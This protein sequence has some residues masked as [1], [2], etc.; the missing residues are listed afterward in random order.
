MLRI[1]GFYN[2]GDKPDKTSRRMEKK[3][4]IDRKHTKYHC[5]VNAKVNLLYEMCNTSESDNFYYSD[6]YKQTACFVVGNIHAY[7]HAGRLILT[8][9]NIA[10]WVANQFIRKGATFLKSLRGNFN[11]ILYHKS[12][13]FLINDALGL[14]PMYIY[15]VSNGILFCS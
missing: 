8:E 13:L 3:F 1:F 5:Y 7:E 9:G 6:D 12:R 14:S 11:I 15:P 4:L 2:F 10:E